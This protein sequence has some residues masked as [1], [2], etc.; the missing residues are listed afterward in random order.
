MWRLWKP[1]VEYELRVAGYDV[2]LQFADAFESMTAIELLRPVIERRDE[3]KQMAAIFVV[4]LGEA[5][6]LGSDT[7][8][9][10]LRSDCDGCDVRRT[11]Q[12]MRGKQDEAQES[13]ILIA[14]DKQVRARADHDRATRIQVALQRDPWLI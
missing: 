5:E 7:S 13:G 3:K 4:P 8:A 14:S 12:T 10:H 2:V 9:P 6:E 11:C 1:F